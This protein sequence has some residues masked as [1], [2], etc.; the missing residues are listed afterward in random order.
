VKANLTGSGASPSDVSVS[1]LLSG[2]GFGTYSLTAS[3]YYTFPNGFILQWGNSGYIYSES[4]VSVSFPV[5]FPTACLSA[6]ATL[7]IPSFTFYYDQVTQIVGTPSQT[8][9]TVAAQRVGGDATY[10]VSVYWFALGY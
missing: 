7:Q 4:S 1:S 2:L 6:Q 9:M 3:G 10:P 8:G 5:R